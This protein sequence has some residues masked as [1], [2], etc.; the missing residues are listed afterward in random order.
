MA[1]LNLQ[2]KYVKNMDALRKLLRGEE[3]EDEL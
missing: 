2:G 3:V 1:K